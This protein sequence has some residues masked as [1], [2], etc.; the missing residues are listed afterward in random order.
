[1]CPGAGNCAFLT[2]KV[3]LAVFHKKMPRQ[4]EEG[5]R[6]EEKEAVVKVAVAD[7]VNIPIVPGHID[8]LKEK[9]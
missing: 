8:H 6:Q 2:G 4:E 9:N 3:P 7:T 1:M 5:Q